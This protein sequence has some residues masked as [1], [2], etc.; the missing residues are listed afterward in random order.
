M[1][2]KVNLEISWN[3]LWRILIF[4]GVLALIISAKE[5]LGVLLIAVFIS[6]AINPAVSWLKKKGVHRILGTLIVFFFIF[7]LFLITIYFLIPVIATELQGF[8]NQIDNL[9]SQ[10]L[11]IEVPKTVIEG[12]SDSLN[13]ILGS[14]QAAN[15]SI[16]GTISKIFN[17]IVLAITTLIISFYLSVEEN[18]TETLIKKV[19]PR[20]Y[21]GP[22]L[23]VFGRFKEK[24][25]FWAIAQLGISLIVGTIVSVG[26]WIFGVKYPLVLGLLAAVFELVPLIGPILSGVVAFLIAIGDSFILGV[27]IGIFFILVQQL[28]N[29]VLIP[30][31]FKKSM[32]IHPVM[33]LV[34]LLAGGYAAGLIGVILSVP[35]A[36]LAQEMINYF[37]EKKRDEELREEKEKEA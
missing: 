30:L 33:V 8:I 15:V 1:S 29:N 16:T 6:L 20:I 32:K 36:L 19:L 24:I 12:L 27:Y 35:I 5:A 4:L 22:V 3:T 28:E 2:E 10:F 21:E 34:V 17:N 18:G 13:Q 23:K 25:R 11:G 14:L 7:L 37:A 9:L 26:L 31:I